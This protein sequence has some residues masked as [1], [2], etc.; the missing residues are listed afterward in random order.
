MQKMLEAQKIERAELERVETENN[1]LILGK[2]NHEKEILQ[3]QQKLKEVS[4]K[5]EEE[6]SSQKDEFFL[7]LEKKN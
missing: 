6:I 5:H 3:L 1:K 4:K 2:N 7:Q